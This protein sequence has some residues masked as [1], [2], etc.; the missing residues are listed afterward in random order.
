MSHEKS[1]LDKCDEAERIAKEKILS[2]KNEQDRIAEDER[3]RKQAALDEEARKQREA[4]EAKARRARSAESK[5]ALRE[6]AASITAPVVAAEQSVPQVDGATSRK[7]FVAEI[8]D[9]KAFLDW[10]F[11]NK[12]YDLVTPNLKTIDAYAKA[13]REKAEMPGV[14]FSPKE[15]LAIGV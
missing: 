5:E 9:V 3:R 14:K 11:A 7:T 2:Y 4:I 8:E 6:Q 15:T 10:V 12:R 13:M 1:F